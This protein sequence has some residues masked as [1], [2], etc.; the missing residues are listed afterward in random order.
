VAQ[1]LNQLRHR[2]PQY[3]V[4]NGKFCGILL[5]EFFSQLFVTTCLVGI[6]IFLSISLS[7]VLY[8]FLPYYKRRRF[9][10]VQNVRQ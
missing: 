1:C 9:A 8:L 2:V 10:S 4:V 6:D 7:E 3:Q 5:F